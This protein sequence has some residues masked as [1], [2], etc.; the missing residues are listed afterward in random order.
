VSGSGEKAIDGVNSSES[1]FTPKT[2]ND[3]GKDEKGTHDIKNVTKFSFRTT[4]LLGGIGTKTMGNSAIRIQNG[5]ERF[6]V[7]LGIV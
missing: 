7:F 5:E 6:V 3:R 2:F 4:I 1:R